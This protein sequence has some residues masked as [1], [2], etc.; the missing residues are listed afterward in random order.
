MTTGNKRVELSTAGTC[1]NLTG[2]G[3]NLTPESN[4][5]LVPASSSG[6]MVTNFSATQRA[7]ATT[8]SNIWGIK[9]ITTTSIGLIISSETVAFELKDLESYN[10]GTSLSKYE[11]TSKLLSMRKSLRDFA[12][13]Q[14]EKAVLIAATALT[15]KNPRTGE[16]IKRY[17]DLHLEVSHLPSW[18]NFKKLFHCLYTFSDGSDD[19]VVQIEE[20]WMNLHGILFLEPLKGKSLSLNSVI[21]S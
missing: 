5:V 10:Q 17:Q 9:H 15:V 12:G 21:V 2:T 1:A 8:S 4:V 16:N 11:W 14:Y 7:S 18:I 6:L 13:M 3:N 20:Q 19:F